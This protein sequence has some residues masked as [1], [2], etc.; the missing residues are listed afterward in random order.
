MCNMLV[1]GSLLYESCDCHIFFMGYASTNI[2]MNV[3]GWGYMDALSGYLSY[4]HWVGL[5]VGV[6]LL[7]YYAYHLL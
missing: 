2:L 5:T 1:P 7:N 3:V 6:V 4:I